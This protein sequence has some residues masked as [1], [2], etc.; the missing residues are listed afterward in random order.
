M[1]DFMCHVSSP[2]AFTEY[3]VWLFNF[4]INFEAE[5][6]DVLWDVS[7]IHPP[8][9]RNYN[10]RFLIFQKDSGLFSP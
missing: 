1:R 5:F 10:L 9:K 8:L 2:S 7:D 6:L 3:A 4:E